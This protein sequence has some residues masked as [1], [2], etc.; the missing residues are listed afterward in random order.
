M[1]IHSVAPTGLD[2][3]LG[4]AFFPGRRFGE[5][6]EGMAA[7]IIF[8]DYRPFTPLTAG[9]LPWHILFGFEASMITTTIVD[10]LVLME[11]RQLTTLDE[12]TIMQE[13]LS[14]APR[15]WERYHTYVENG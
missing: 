8:V 14:L 2:G 4:D 9:N 6:A 3:E 10:G 5:L 7:D 13:A 11:D 1:R 12:A 15:V